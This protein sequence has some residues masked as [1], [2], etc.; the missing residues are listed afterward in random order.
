[1]PNRRQE[2]QQA[3]TTRD[4]IG[5]LDVVVVE[6]SSPWILRSSCLNDRSIYYKLPSPDSAH[7]LALIDITRGVPEPME[8]VDNQLEGQVSCNMRVTFLIRINLAATQLGR[9]LTD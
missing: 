7:I 5:F 4:P 6:P 1:M 9:V 3:Y 8:L 2:P